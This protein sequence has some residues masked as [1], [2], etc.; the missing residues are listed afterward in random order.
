MS[1]KAGRRDGPVDT[2]R[3]LHRTCTCRER[4]PCA[5]G[6]LHVQSVGLGGMGGRFGTAAH[7]HAS[8]ARRSSAVQAA[9]GGQGHDIDGGDGIRRSTRVG[10]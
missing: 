1:H 7:L 2:S 10:Q 8:L 6:A 3:S 4:R 9:I 5:H